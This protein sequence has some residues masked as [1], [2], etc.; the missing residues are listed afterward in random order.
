MLPNG[1]VRRTWWI[2]LA[3]LTIL[4]QAIF[5]EAAYRSLDSSSPDT[6]GARLSGIGAI[7]LGALGCWILWRRHDLR[8][9]RRKFI[10]LMVVSCVA[11]ILFANSISFQ[12]FTSWFESHTLGT[13]F[14]ALFLALI[15]FACWIV[16]RRTKGDRERWRTHIPTLVLTFG[17][18]GFAVT[19]VY[20]ILFVAS[21]AN[22]ARQAHGHDS[23]SLQV[24]AVLASL[25]VATAC[26]RGWRPT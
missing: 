9:E 25:L 8:D 23:A 21:M 17:A 16:G 24:V 2:A 22:Q 18:V 5:L 1:Q 12:P 19:G 7:V 6:G 20:M 11:G 13:F 4:V 14:Q 3:T 10:A 15:V 26:R